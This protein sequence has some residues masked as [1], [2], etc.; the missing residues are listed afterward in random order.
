M[1]RFYLGAKPH[2]LAH[3]GVPLFV[4]NPHLRDVKR[5]P[6]ARGP[7]A[8]DSGGFTELQRHG[9]WT[10]TPAQYVTELHRHRE[11]IG[12]LEWAAPQ[13]WMCEDAIIHG[14][15]VGGLHFTGTGLSVVEHQHRTVGNFVDLRAL[16]D[17]LPI[18]PV[19]Q[20]RT[21]AEY[22]HCINLYDR[23]G[24]RLTDYPVVGIGSVCRIQA[25]EEAADIVEH[26]AAIVGPGRLH[27][28]GFKIDGLRRVGHLLGSADSHAWSLHGRRTSG[29]GCDFR[30]PRSRGP[31][32]NEANCLRFALAWRA[33]VLE[34]IAE[35]A[36]AP[37]Q[38]RLDFHTTALAA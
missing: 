9:R 33:R 26:V 32:K 20:G 31:H 4:A 24:V 1:T 5:L 7:W 35:G 28:F 8:E 21:P 6:Q 15:T 25:T 37:R 23:A 12:R 16:D 17:T 38:L 13:D 14:G 19:L 34:A 11:E 18:I 30:L 29:D 22:E 2:M 27:G 3:T 36:T 10:R